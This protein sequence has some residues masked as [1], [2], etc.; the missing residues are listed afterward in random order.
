MC[1]IPVS[2]YPVVQTYSN[3]QPVID[4]SLDFS[5]GLS[6]SE[7]S[8]PLLKLFYCMAPELPERETSFSHLTDQAVSETDEINFGLLQDVVLGFKSL[9]FSM[10]GFGNSSI[11]S[12]RIFRDAGPLLSFLPD[13]GGLRRSRI[14]SS[15]T[16]GTT[17]TRHCCACA[18]ETARKTRSSS[19][20]C[21]RLGNCVCVSKL[22]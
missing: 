4:P 19:T 11:R 13:G 16:S 8:L 1:L 6:C 7:E 3:F 9:R 15:A 14:L 12:P 20:G 10:L 18:W 21:C 5:L 2:K 22:S 17:F